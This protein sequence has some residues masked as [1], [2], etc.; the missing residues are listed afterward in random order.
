[1]GEW[2]CLVS[3][4]SRG[5]D[6]SSQTN[7]WEVQGER[8]V[9]KNVPVSVCFLDQCFGRLPMQDGDGLQRLP[10]CQGWVLVVIID[11][12]LSLFKEMPGELSR[13]K[14]YLRYWLPRKLQ[15]QAARRVTR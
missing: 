11:W 6:F 2:A 13:D 15:L 14:S 5:I 8:H 7:V 10:P 12:C 4:Q 3:W 1:M 9:R